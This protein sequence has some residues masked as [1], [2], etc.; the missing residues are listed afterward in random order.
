MQRYFVN[1]DNDR[2]VLSNSDFHHVKDV[3]RIKN[4]GQIICVYNNQSYLCSIN[5]FE[6]GYTINVIEERVTEADALVNNGAEQLRQ[7]RI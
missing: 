4:D 6:N 3:M 2:F 1:K 5:Y 7:T